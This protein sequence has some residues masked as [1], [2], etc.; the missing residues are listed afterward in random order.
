M[1]RSRSMFSM[2]MALTVVALFTHCEDELLTSIDQP[3]NINAKGGGGKGGGGGHVEGAGNNLSFPVIWS[4][5]RELTL[6]ELPV[7]TTDPILDGAWWYVWGPEPIDPSSPIYSCDP[8][9]SDPC[10]PEGT[11]DVYQAY[12]QKDPDNI[13]QAFNE[14][15]TS[16]VYV[17]A[18]DWGDNLES[19]DWS[20]TSKV[21]TE[22]VLYENL[23]SASLTLPDVTY[24][25]TEYAMQH[26]SGW[27]TDEV[28]GLQT[29]LNGDIVE[30]PGNRATIFSPLARLTIQ[31]LTS[32]TPNLTWD[33]TTHS[34]TG[35]ANSPVFNSAVHEAAD[36]PGYYNAE[37]NV[38]GKI[39]F[40]YT[41]DVKKLSTGPG[42][43]RITFSFDE[44]GGGINQLN[45]FFDTNTQIVPPAEE[46]EIVVAEEPGGGGTAVI[47]VDYNL[48]YI[49]VRITS[50]GGGGG[51]GGG[52]GKPAR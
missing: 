38:K 46:G 2:A 22:V 49:D 36:G 1:I 32:T 41:W 12:L 3:I 48:S 40:G 17:D 7:G 26:V 42:V 47:D 27:G 33:A 29:E 10:Y 19:V 28:H 6:R 24:P 39:I 20:I 16:E 52:K 14:P 35:D 43:Y 18:I 5:G 15:A 34:W 25:V 51:K 9:I 30:G 37:V 11:P 21:R 4:E 13:W 45:T 31:Q 50:S 44:S 23:P 8:T